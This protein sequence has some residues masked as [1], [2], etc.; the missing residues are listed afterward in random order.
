MSRMRVVYLGRIA[1]LAGG[2]LATALYCFPVSFVIPL[3][4]G[5]VTREAG[6]TY[7]TTMLRVVRKWLGLGWLLDHDSD[8]RARRSVSTAELFE[9]G[10]RL[11]PGHAD[12]AE[13]AELGAGRYSQWGD[14]LV[15]SAS[16][17]SS[18]QSNGRS[19]AIK[20]PVFP[21]WWLA[22]ALLA[23]GLCLRLGPR[24]RSDVPVRG[25]REDSTGSRLGQRARCWLV[26]RL[27]SR[28]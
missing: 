7:A 17:N 12:H 16:D 22:V 13:I 11:G 8:S 18:P 24:T 15:F 10:R 4:P 1:L 26:D 25:M 3:D 19:Y 6:H 21:P 2:L 20:L 9:G 14:T 27:R 23:A 5:L 28:R